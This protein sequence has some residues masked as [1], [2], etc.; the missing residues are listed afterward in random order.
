VVTAGQDRTLRVWHKNGKLVT[1]HRGFRGEVI[2]LGLGGGGRWA[3]A[4][5]MTGEVVAVDL[6]ATPGK[7]LVLAPYRTRLAMVHGKLAAFR[8]GEVRWHDAE[9]LVETTLWPA[10][11]V[12]E[13][14]EREKVQ[15]QGAAFAAR[16]DGE[17]AHGG[18]G[19]NGPG[20]VVWR[21]PSGE[22]RRLLVGHGAAISAVAF[23]PGDRLASADEA[24]GIRIWSGADG[25]A[26]TTLHPWNGPVHFL[27]ATRDGRLWAGGALESP[28]NPPRGGSPPPPSP[29]RL[30]RIEEGKVAW[31]IT[32]PAALLAGALA[33]DGKALLVGDADG[34]LVWHD[35]RTGAETH[36]QAA[37]ARAAIVALQFSPTEPRIAVGGADGVVRL[38]D[39]GSGEELLVLE[40][41]SESVSGLAFF[42]DGRRLAAAAAVLSGGAVIVW[43][44]SPAGAWAPPRGPDA[45][46]RRSRL[47]S[48]SQGDDPNTPFIRD[49]FAMRYH[50]NRLAEMEPNDIHWRRN[51]LA[52]DQDA[53]DFRGAAARLGDIVQRWPDNAPMWYDLGNARREL[54]DVPGAESAFRKCISLTPTMPE[55]HCNLGLL[56]G[57]E[58]RF[59]EAVTSLARGHELGM[60]Q[61]AKGQPWNYPSAAWLAHHQRLSD[62]AARYGEQKDLSATPQDE[63][64]DLVEVLTL[65]KRPLAAVRLADPKPVPSPGPTV[66]GAALRCGEG[67]GDAK[68]LTASDRSAWRAKALA[69]LRLD[70][71]HIRALEPNQ[72][73]RNIAGMRAH[74]L[75]QISQGDRTASWPAAEREVWQRFWS[76]VD[77][78][79]RSP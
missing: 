12:T 4:G 31:D 40:G 10:A 6:D 5:T 15:S 78:A 69:W 57:R 53:R 62:L 39:A 7:R 54:G 66:I 44:A 21:R 49:T 11:K 37:L 52:L 23:L 19:Y 8:F 38:L 50:L 70:C 22:V 14:K 61:Q 79:A 77:A 65:I 67:I 30:A 1:E 58:G 20:T 28:G 27:A 24:G 76:E 74:P 34:A 64:R 72:W 35:A 25:Q 16:P 13:P 63:R 3:V 41:A 55:A 18:H 71:E 51:L 26:L 45:A 17:V 73:A 36:R 68:D 59:A 33:P 47:A 46:W 42:P 60:A 48:A 2:G 75:L 43:E 32:T 9:T 56:V 29:G